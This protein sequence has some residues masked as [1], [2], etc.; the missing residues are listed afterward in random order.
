M[1]LG[2]AL[3]APARPLELLQRE[4]TSCMAE[5]T[6]VA[7]YAGPLR[8]EPCLCGG[9]IAAQGDSEAVMASVA[10]HNDTIGHQA[11]RTWQE[12]R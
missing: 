8:V 1:T 9:S 11:W 4:P 12:A 6:L 3:P 5:A 7:A 2:L 10:A